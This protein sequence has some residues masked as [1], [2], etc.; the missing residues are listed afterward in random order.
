MPPP[1][2][3]PLSPV[4]ITLGPP[5]AGLEWDGCQPSW[6][7]IWRA[8]KAVWASKWNSRA[9]SSLRKAGLQHEHLQMAV[10]C[11]SVIPAKY[12]FV[13]H[14]TNPV[15]GEVQPCRQLLATSIAGL[16]SVPCGM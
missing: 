6:K 4:P 7:D 16:L 5:P 15:T 9:V 1:P 14:T 3:R 11:Q 2:L 13:A 10:L 12:A 8:I